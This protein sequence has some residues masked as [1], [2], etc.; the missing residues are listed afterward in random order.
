MKLGLLVVEL[1]LNS[2]QW[3]FGETPPEHCAVAP[4]DDST[5]AKLWEAYLVAPDRRAITG[6]SRP[7][8]SRP[9]KTSKRA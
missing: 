9:H 8:E 3:A 6:G 4:E 1:P 7:G 2:V 5:L